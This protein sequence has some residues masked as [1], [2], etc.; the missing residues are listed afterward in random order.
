MTPKNAAPTTK[1]GFVLSKPVAKSFMFLK[2][3]DGKD[4][5]VHSSECTDDFQ[6]FSIK[7]SVEFEPY[8]SEKGPRARNVTLIHHPGNVK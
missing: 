1:Q 2:G 7:D 6:A 3:H 4:Y 8:D 5:F